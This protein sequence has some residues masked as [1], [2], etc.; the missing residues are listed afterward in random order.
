MSSI[1]VVSRSRGV[2]SN[3]G[4]ETAKPS[5]PELHEEMPASSNDLQIPVKELDALLAVYGT[6]RSFSF[7]LR[8]SPFPLKILCFELNQ[9]RM[10]SLIDEVCVSV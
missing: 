3:G 9:P 5:L 7:L 1:A 8:L 6:L 2:A 10:S 4:K